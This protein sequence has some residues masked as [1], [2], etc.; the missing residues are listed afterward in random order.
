MR[1]KKE[2]ED[3][4]PSSNE[5][6]TPGATRAYGWQGDQQALA[7]AEA[8]V[9]S[10]WKVGDVILDTY[11]VTSLLGEGGFGKVYKVHHRGWNTDL[12][13]KSPRAE[14]LAQLVV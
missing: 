9:A 1:K 13:V 10:D 2:K 11:E 14:I 12:A 7:Q 4:L 8:Q 5:T 3:R 6:S